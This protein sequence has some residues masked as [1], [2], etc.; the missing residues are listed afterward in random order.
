MLSNLQ[1]SKPSLYLCSFL[2]VTQFINGFNAVG[3]NRSEISNFW[4][5]LAFYWALNWW[6]IA[7]SRTHGAAWTKSYLDMGMFLYVAG[8]FIVPYYLF[9]TRGWK[10]LY[11]IGLFLAVLFGAYVVG[12]I[13][14]LFPNIF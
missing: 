9:K 10:A 6:F 13:F 7:D 3:N 11:T 8:F 5:A 14:H 1:I 4:Y 2:L 12:A